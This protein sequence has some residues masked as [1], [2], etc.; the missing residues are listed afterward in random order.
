MEEMEPMVELTGDI[1]ELDSLQWWSAQSKSP[2]DSIVKEDEKYWLKSS[3]FDADTDS[4]SLRR[5]AEE[6]LPI[7]KGTQLVRA[8]ACRTIKIGSQIKRSKQTT[9]AVVSV[10]TARENV[11]FWKD[12]DIYYLKYADK[13][14]EI[15]SEPPKFYTDLGFKITELRE[16]IRKGRAIDGYLH[17]LE[18]CIDNPYV[19][20]AFS[21]FVEEP[22]WLSLW[23]TYEMIK[24]DVDDNLDQEF[25][26]GKCAITRNGWAEKLELERFSNTANHY[27]AEGNP[28]HSYAR[29]SEDEKR[30]KSNPYKEQKHK[31]RLKKYEENNPLMTPGVAKELIQRIFRG[32]CKWKASKC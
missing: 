5:Q 25:S 13:L 16:K 7:I 26:A 18:D 29:F 28:R 9:D 31:E 2:L 21:Y 3:R 22:T 19:Y 15:G 32:W 23:K 27:Q 8:V 30:S 12:N 11:M 4:P 20:E 24:Y 17:K 6:M 14:L 10:E 1:F